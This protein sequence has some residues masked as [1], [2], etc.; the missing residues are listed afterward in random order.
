MKTAAIPANQNFMFDLQ[1]DGVARF[2]SLDSLT[3]LSHPLAKKHVHR[4]LSEHVAR[5]LVS[6]RK[7]IDSA[8]QMLAGAEQHRPDRKMH[9][10]DETCLQILPDRRNP[11]SQAHVA[12]AGSG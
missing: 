2:D 8:E 10:V 1:V 7:Q 5:A 12:G 3:C 11:A 6:Q 4:S 9:L